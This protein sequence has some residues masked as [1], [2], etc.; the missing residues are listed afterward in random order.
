M[1][2]W[3]DQDRSLLLLAIIE[4]LVPPRSQNRLPQW[5]DVAERMGKGFTQEAV[6]YYIGSQNENV[7][8]IGTF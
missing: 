6:R 4:L 5:G 8:Y 3:T 1:P 2:T 7:L